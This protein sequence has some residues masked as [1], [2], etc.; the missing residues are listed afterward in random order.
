MAI[1]ESDNG[2]GATVKAGADVADGAPALLCS[3]VI[4]GFHS[5]A[6]LDGCLRSLFGDVPRSDRR[7]EAIFV[8]NSSADQTEVAA[9]CDAHGAV[10]VQN[11]ANLGY[12]Q[13]CNLGAQRASGT[14]LLF[15]N[16]DVRITPSDVETLA[17][18][19]RSQPDIVAIGPMQ[20]GPNG[21]IK[22][23]RHS[24]GQ[25]RPPAAADADA[26]LMMTGFLSGG[27]FMVRRDAFERVGGFDPRIFLFH[28]DDDICLRLAK[29]GRLAYAR[30]VVVPHEWGASTPPSRDVTRARSWHL[31]YSKTYVLQKH[32]GRRAG[33]RA[34]ADAV[35]KFVNPLMLTA[36]GRL[37]A[38]AF[39]GGVVAGLKQDSIS[40]RNVPK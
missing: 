33:L 35:L 3:V 30:Q 1:K 8:N 12:G 19:A 16:P 17:A 38:T 29:V 24:A 20:Q 36:R 5:G 31:G 37:K 26:P 11:G 22:A 25:P 40:V 4:V 14:F 23:K 6:K 39:F 13:G 2:S 28:E 18:L 27:A 15:L 9:I 7:V 34:V 10:F 32:Y 21:R